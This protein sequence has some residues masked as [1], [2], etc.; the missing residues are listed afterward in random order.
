MYNELLAGLFDA[1]KITNGQAKIDYLESLQ[2]H[3][4]TLRNS[5]NN[6]P[7]TFDYTNKDIQAAY[8]LC[9]L[10]HYTDLVWK[11]LESCDK[12]AFSNIN[13]LIL[14]GSGPCPEL[15]GYL[16]HVKE[17][18]PDIKRD[19]KV[20]VYDKA[21]EEWQW[22][23]H[24]V[25]NYV[26]PKF[27]NNSTLTRFKSKVDISKALS[28]KT[29]S[30][31]KLC[32]FQNCLNEIS[33]WDH[34]N[35]KDNVKAVF[36]NMASG[37]YLAIIDLWYWQVNKLVTE[38]E[39]ELEIEFGCEVIRSV[40]DGQ[41]QHRSTFGFPVELIT[42]HLLTDIPGQDPTGLLPRRNINFLYTLIKKKER[43]KN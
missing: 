4:R 32:V 3:V 5:Y 41:I 22:S 27:L 1:H 42:K 33:E 19:I 28:A 6:F 11:A 24:I 17:K 9:Y 43:S 37:S 34:A 36:E 2:P 20:T 12:F 25:Y 40:K 10:P 26:A 7:V 39:E 15:I 13:E 16:R 29:E 35:V 8:I 38:I 14:F 31:K 30:E 18:T 21:V 23:R